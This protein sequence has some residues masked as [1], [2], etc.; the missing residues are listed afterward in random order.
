MRRCKSASE[1]SEEVAQGS[2]KLEGARSYR[3]SEVE[4]APGGCLGIISNET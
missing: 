3:N 4:L 1:I 2:P